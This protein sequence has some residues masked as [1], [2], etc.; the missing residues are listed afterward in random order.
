MPAG[1]RCSAQ[2]GIELARNELT[3][4]DVSLAVDNEVHGRPIRDGEQMFQSVV[5]GLQSSE[6]SIGA[7]DAGVENV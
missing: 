3:R 4:G 1:R 7:R 5:C 6:G 2:S